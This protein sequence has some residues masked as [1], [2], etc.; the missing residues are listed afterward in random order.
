MPVARAV[1]SPTIREEMGNKFVH[2]VIKE[3]LPAD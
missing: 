1:V 3:F 2:L